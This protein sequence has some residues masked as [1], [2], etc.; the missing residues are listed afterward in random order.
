MLGK[1]L[2]NTLIFAYMHNT[3]HLSILQQVNYLGIGDL[4]D[5]FR[6]QLIRNNGL[7]TPQ[8]DPAGLIQS[9]HISSLIPKLWL[10]LD[11]YH[12]FYHF[13]FL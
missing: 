5:S 6:Q 10:K 2:L 11:D 12:D 1:H 13:L 3:F 8:G 9:H 4:V 7:E